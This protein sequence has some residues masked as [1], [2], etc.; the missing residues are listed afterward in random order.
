MRII[1]LAVILGIAPSAVAL[2][3]FLA[4]GRRGRADGAMQA[5]SALARGG[6]S[7]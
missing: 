7:E 3:V 6:G 2:G 1:V 4:A 5:V